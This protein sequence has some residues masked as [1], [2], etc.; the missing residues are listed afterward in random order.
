M[1][2]YGGFLNSEAG[3]GI[4][5][6]YGKSFERLDFPFQIH[7]EVTIPPG[8]YTYDGL[9]TFFTTFGGRWWSVGGEANI[10]EFYDGNI[11]TVSPGMVF[12]VSKN[13]SFAPTFSYNKIDLPGGSF[14]NNVVNARINYSFSDRL[15]T[16]TLL[17]Y[18]NVSN[19]VSVFARLRY[20]YRVGDDI[21]L[22]YRQA[23][24]YDGLRFGRHN[25][26]LTLKVTRSFDW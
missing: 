1:Q 26:S 14:M 24:A 13:F 4:G 9:Y 18:G 2:W 6:Y 3:D 21:Y 12:R 22:V 5:L 25:R 11:V 23:G 19:S 17:Q 16:D 10:S 8:E 20:I 7:P 15:L